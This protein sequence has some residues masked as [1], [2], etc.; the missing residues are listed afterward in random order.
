MS[1][2]YRKSRINIQS[3]RPWIT[4]VVI[5]S[6]LLMATTGV[7]M[8]FHLDR[9][10][11]KAVHEWLSWAMVG[12][13]MLHVTLNFSLFKRYLQQKLALGLIGSFALVLAMSFVQWGPPKQEPAYMASIKA[14]SASPLRV[15]AQVANVPATEIVRRLQ[16]AGFAQVTEDST[17][18]QLAGA[19][20]RRQTTVLKQAFVTAP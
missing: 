5:G 6:F 20:L 14:L 4:P 15:V 1:P 2:F 16:S 7:L 19:D 10:V 3:Q 17:V 8:F 13:V 18:A 12:G 9:G 11:N